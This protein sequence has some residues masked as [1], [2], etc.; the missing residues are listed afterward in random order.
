MQNFFGGFAAFLRAA[1]HNQ[2]GLALGSSLGFFGKAARAA[3]ILGDKVTDVEL[4]HQCKVQFQ[5]KGPLHG[6]DVA[7]RDARA[8]ARRNA[9]HGGQHP[10]VQAGGIQPGK[11]RKLLGAGGEQNIALCCG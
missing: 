7:V 5:R 8:L 10:R 1:Q 2:R 9:C 11:G 4:L 6:N 3:A